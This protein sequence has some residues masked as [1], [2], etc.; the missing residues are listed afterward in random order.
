MLVKLT[1][2]VVVTVVTDSF[3]WVK[4][5]MRSAVDCG[6]TGDLA[7]DRTGDSLCALSFLAYVD[8]GCFYHV[9]GDV[10]RPVMV[11]SF[12]EHKYRKELESLRWLLSFIGVF[13]CL[14]RGSFVLF[15]VYFMFFTQ[16]L[17]GQRFVHNCGWF[18]RR[19]G[20]RVVL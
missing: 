2:E 3:V 18:C 15:R 10:L 1:G 8:L 19:N 14:C 17:A 13:V 4:Q 16:M 6:V 12:I 11:R 7:A 9:V 20:T 5:G